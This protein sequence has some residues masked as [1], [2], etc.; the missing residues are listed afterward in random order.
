M[1][2]TTSF[3]NHST[4]PALVFLFFLASYPKS[5]SFTFIFYLLLLLNLLIQAWLIFINKTCAG[6]KQAVS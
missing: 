3:N 6:K 1:N 2:E 4:Y 5:Q